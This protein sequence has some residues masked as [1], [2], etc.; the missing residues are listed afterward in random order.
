MGLAWR[1]GPLQ[2]DCIEL[3]LMQGKQDAGKAGGAAG[4]LACLSCSAKQGKCSGKGREMQTICM[5]DRMMLEV[6]QQQ[7]CFSSTLAADQLRLW[8]AGCRRRLDGAPMQRDLP[9]SM[10]VHVR[11]GD[12]TMMVIIRRECNQRRVD[13]IP[14]PDPVNRPAAGRRLGP[15]SAPARGRPVGAPPGCGAPGGAASSPSR[16]GLSSRVSWVI[17]PSAA[18]PY[19]TIT[20]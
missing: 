18:P 14:L 16:G 17:R 4:S 6:R 11:R 7:A 12:C 13:L 9:Y 19:F 20:L 2:A 15:P 1:T 8:R 10:S 5:H 3:M